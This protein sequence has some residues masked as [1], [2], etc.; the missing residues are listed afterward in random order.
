MLDKKIINDFI[1]LVEKTQDENR[2]P[3]NLV[4][5]EFQDGLKLVYF[6]DLAEINVGDVVTVDG[7]MK[8]QVAEVTKVLSSF[9]KP[10]FD[11]QWITGVIDNDVTGKYFVSKEDVVSF[12]TRLSAEKFMN[13]YAGTK[14]VANDP[15]GEDDIEL[16]LNDLEKSELFED[17]GVKERG[18]EMYKNGYVCF[19]SLKNGTG[20]AIVRS[21]N[22]HDWYEVD[23]RYYNGKITYLACDCPYFEGCKHGYAVLLKLRELLKKICKE[24]GTQ[25]FTVCKKGC[26]NYI[27]LYAKGKVEIEL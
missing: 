21:S 20:K 27:M 1:E 9:K 4:Q 2:K 13:I 3:K 8:G 12:E 25:D 10:K 24:Y 15:V 19:I 6:S 7:K 18:Y 26:F 23:Y 14:Y 22:A 11:M 16:D 17:Q 5:V